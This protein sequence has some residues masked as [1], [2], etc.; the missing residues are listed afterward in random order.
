[1]WKIHIFVPNL[2]GYNQLIFDLEVMGILQIKM[3]G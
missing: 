1:M 2:I 3:T